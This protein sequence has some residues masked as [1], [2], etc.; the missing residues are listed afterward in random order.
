MTCAACLREIAAA[1]RRG[2]RRPRFWLRPLQA[3]YRVGQLAA[4]VLAAWYFFHSLGHYLAR[5][6]DE[7]HAGTLWETVTGGGHHGD[8]G[9]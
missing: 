6:S 1:S 8:D 3:A 2:G 9:D 7:F 4:S 5:G